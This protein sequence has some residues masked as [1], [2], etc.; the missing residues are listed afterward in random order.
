MIDHLSDNWGFYIC[1]VI[2]G[3]LI[4]VGVSAAAYDHAATEACYAQNMVVVDTDAGKRCA[5]LDALYP[6]R[7]K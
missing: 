6:V 3:G 1:A 2:C 7:V 5:S 4:W